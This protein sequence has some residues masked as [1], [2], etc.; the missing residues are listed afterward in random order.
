[1]VGSPRVAKSARGGLPGGFLTYLL[2]ARSKLS[3]LMLYQLIIG[4]NYTRNL[5]ASPQEQRYH[6]SCSSS[7]FPNST[8]SGSEF[9]PHCNW[10]I[11]GPPV[12]RLIALDESERAP[13]KGA[14]TCGLSFGLID[15]L[16]L[17]MDHLCSRN[18]M[19]VLFYFHLNFFVSILKY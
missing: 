10:Q 2:L 3:M 12:G 9:N 15:Q 13:I 4:T 19:V 14:Y 11:C 6:C 17:S 7:F 18:Q 16:T 5:H 1:M 8:F